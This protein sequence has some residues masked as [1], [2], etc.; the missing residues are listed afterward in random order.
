MSVNAHC[1]WE[2]NEIRINHKDNTYILMEEVNL[3]VYTC[4]ICKNGQLHLSLTE[5]EELL[6]SLS[7]AI[8]SYK[9]LDELANLDPL[10]NK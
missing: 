6:S 2:V 4:G 8:N 1:Y 9:K 3:Q 5:A 7:N 10:Y